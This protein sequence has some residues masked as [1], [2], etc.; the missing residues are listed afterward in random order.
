MC[1]AQAC[2]LI[3]A[4]IMDQ[5]QNAAPNYSTLPQNGTTSSPSA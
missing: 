1:E 2:D 4:L 3:A 5:S